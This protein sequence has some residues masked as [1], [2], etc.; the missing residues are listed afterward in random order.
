MAMGFGFLQGG[1]DPPNLRLHDFLLELAEKV[2]CFLIFSH[3]QQGVQ[4][5]PPRES[6]VFRKGQCLPQQRSELKERQN[7]GAKFSTVVS[8]DQRKF[9]GGGRHLKF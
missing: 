5:Q 6:E 3:L 9:L 1:N 2:Q 8:W 7:T 4:R